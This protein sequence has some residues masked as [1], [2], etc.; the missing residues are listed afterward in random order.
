M[1]S[2]TQVKDEKIINVLEDV[3]ESLSKIFGT[4][5]KKIIL[6]G[7]YARD[8]ADDESD[9]DIISVVNKF[10]VEIIYY[11]KLVVPLEN[12]LLLLI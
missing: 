4:K 1:K 9:I 2:G 12:S 8:E 11:L 3:K 6:F 10:I 5:L 7:S